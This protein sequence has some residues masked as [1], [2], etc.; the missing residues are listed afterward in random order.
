VKKPV[1]SF[2]LVFFLPCL[3]AWAG[4]PPPLVVRGENQALRIEGKLYQDASAIE[5]I[6]GHPLPKGIVV[7][8]VT[9]TPKGNDP[10]KVWR[11][12]FLL[13]SFKDGQVSEPFEPSQ[14]AGEA[15]L[16]VGY[17]GPGGG[18]MSEDR[19]PIWGGLGGGRPRRVGGEG[20]NIGSTDSPGEMR[21]R[22]DRETKEENPLLTLL[23]RKLLPQGQLDGPVSGLL[24]FPLEG[25]HKASQL[26]LD[27]KGAGGTLHLPFQQLK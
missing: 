4:S 3:A 23:Q 2:P 5:R 9:L 21:T 24:Y 7:L 20:G 27:F 19:G 8:E 22:I 6:L 11:D 18:I 12:E 16:V 14:I 10:V 15:V 26:Q 25:R 1:L 13:R 17:S